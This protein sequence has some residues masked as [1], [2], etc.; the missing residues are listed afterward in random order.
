MHLDRPRAPLRLGFGLAV[1]AVC[2]APLSGCAEFLERT[3]AP[4]DPGPSTSLAPEDSSV[5]TNDTIGGATARSAFGE[6][7]LP[8]GVS[9]W[10]SDVG[11]YFGITRSGDQVVTARAGMG[12][13]RCFFGVIDEGVLKGRYRALTAGA[14]LDRQADPIRVTREGERLTFVERAT[15]T[16]LGDYRPVPSSDA[17]GIVV[18]DEALAACEQMR[19]AP[20]T[21]TPQ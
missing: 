12:N 20:A 19:V 1:L 3:A 16:V 9:Q 7:P 21:A 13:P 6:V 8:E 2:L 17:A 10:V 18:V 11:I 4:A 14:G 5:P 15:G